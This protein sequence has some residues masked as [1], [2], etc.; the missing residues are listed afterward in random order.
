MGPPNGIPGRKRTVFGLHP[1]KTNMKMKTQPFE[2]LLKNGDVPLS[3]KFSQGFIL[4]NH[5]APA[6]GHLPP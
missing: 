1:P 5:G 4:G 2:L 6:P 3:S